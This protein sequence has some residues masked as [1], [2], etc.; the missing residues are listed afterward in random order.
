MLDVFHCATNIPST[1]AR[2]VPAALTHTLRRNISE[3]SCRMMVFA[4]NPSPVEVSPCDPLTRV[5]RAVNLLLP[6]LRA[7][8]P[9]V[10]QRHPN[11]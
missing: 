8:M 6:S 11:T 2:R 1:A 3:T 7:G 10:T 4:N 9:N 5:H